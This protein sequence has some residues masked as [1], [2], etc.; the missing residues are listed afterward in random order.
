MIAPRARRG[1]GTPAFCACL[2][3]AACGFLAL[4]PWHG[5]TVVALSEQ[6]GVDA[7]DLPAFALVALAGAVWRARPGRARTDRDGPGERFAA[8]AIVVLGVLLAA[9]IVDPRIGSPLV[10]AAGGTFDGDTLHVDGRRAEPVG[11]WTHLAVT[12]DGAMVRLYVDGDQVSSVAVCGTIL[13]TS[14]PLWIGG[15]RPYGEYFRG[16]I[17]EARVYRRALG[18]AAVRAAMSTPIGHRDDAWSRGLVAAYA[19]DD[20][21]A[22]RVADASGHGNTGTVRGATR[23][24][25]GRFGPGMT[26]TGAGDV[27]RVPASASLDLTTALTLMAWV[28]PAEPQP[29]WRTILAR[30]TDAY[31]LAAGGGRQ[32]ARQ[33]ETLDRL[34]F[35]LVLLVAAWTGWALARGRTPWPQGRGRWY[36]PLAVFIAG[37]LAD[38][39]LAPSGTVIGP[40]LVAGW[41]AVTASRRRDSAAMAA[42][43]A[44]FAAV[45]ILSIAAPGALP[46]PQDAGGVVRSAAVGLLLATA[47]L[48][49]LSPATQARAVGG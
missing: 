39:A 1:R 37:S 5:P 48:L 15:N 17:D 21:D 19:F 41:W 42:L 9:G 4:E 20:R 13:R 45:T 25:A 36:W 27:I 26:F 31:F 22:S 14:D 49:R 8:V 35:V 40:A 7:A 46:L 6:H 38:V 43:A 34:R 10:P 29:G 16:V 30:Q 32:G 11:R 47:G 23:T 12:Y 18:A 3:A 33:L 44:T 28:R 24:H 2:L